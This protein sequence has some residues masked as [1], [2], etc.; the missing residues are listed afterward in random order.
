[1]NQVNIIPVSE[2]IL[3]NAFASDFNDVEDA[4]QFF[5]AQTV[6][7]IQCIITRILKTIRKARYQF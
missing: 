1:M 7:Q 6:Q 3:K 5:S 4:V 2:E